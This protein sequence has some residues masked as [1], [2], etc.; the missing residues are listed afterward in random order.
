MLGNFEQNR[1]ANPSVPVKQPTLTGDVYIKKH[2]RT[3]LFKKAVSI[4]KGG[5]GRYY[6]MNNGVRLCAVHRSENKWIV[7]SK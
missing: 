1:V 6:W 4:K 3:V 7:S 2:A 5:F